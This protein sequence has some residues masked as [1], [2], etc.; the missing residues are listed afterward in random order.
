MPPFRAPA[1]L[2]REPAGSP[3]ATTAL[4]PD[5]S[6]S[7]VYL[8]ATVAALGGLLFGFDT[9][10]INGAL[11]FLKKDFQLSDSETE[12]A[13]SS[14]LFGAVIG[15][16]LAGWLTD[17][18]GRRRLLFAAAALF[19]ASALAAAVPRTLTEFVLARLAGGLAIGLASLLVPLYIAEIAPARIRGRLVTLN[20]LAIVTGILLAYVA[21]YFL[22]DLGLNS[23]RWMF[24]SAALPSLL[25]MLTLLLVP[26]SPRWQLGQG[27]EAAAR[28]TLTRLN[29]PV[30]AAA[31]AEEIQGALAAER[32]EEARLRQPRLR[33]PLRIAVVLAVLQQITG[34]NTIL[35]Y[36]SII[37]TEH[38]GQSAASAIGANALIGGINFVGTVVA[39]FVIDRIGRKP[40]LLLASGGMA[41]ALGALVVA[42]QLHASGPWLLG[43][44]MLYVACFAVGLGPGVWVVITEIFPNAVRG[45]AAS[46]A[47]VALW[48]ACT[49]I[50]F[51]FL[52]LVKAAGL[53]G[54]FGLYA[55][56]SA[57]TFV[58]VWRAVPETKERTLEEIE[59][60]WQ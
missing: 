17:R 45:R 41:L 5:G 21:S 12:W 51:T 3:T 52:S 36:G 33:Q 26:E 37:F 23:W 34:I 57:L 46:L 6:T 8:I 28:R 38:S 24:A 13:A 15:A 19:T 58:F 29:G 59:R 60:T 7:Y 54:A 50:S 56:L 27:R 55:G 44:I 18:Y 35:Y 9:A 22:A 14:I 47:T 39:L 20:Q 40:L 1:P 16:A 30:A 32:G 11:I 10:I 25:F 4:A 49:L 53:S 2:F 48:I 31:E 42:L 43:L